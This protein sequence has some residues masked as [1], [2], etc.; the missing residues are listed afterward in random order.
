MA[1]LTDDLIAN[2]EI[3]PRPYLIWDDATRNFGVRVAVSGRLT[4]FV[5]YRD[6]ER[7]PRFMT[8]G[9]CGDTPLET[10]RAQALSVLLAVAK[11]RYPVRPKKVNRL[12]PKAYRSTTE[13]SYPS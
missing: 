7:R 5:Y 10:A 2:I 8:I 3:A 13:E 1:T 6:G 11:R 12:I 4:F 9:V